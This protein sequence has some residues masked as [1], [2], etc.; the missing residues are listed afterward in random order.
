MLLLRWS[1]LRISSGSSPLTR[2]IFFDGLIR[3]QPLSM[4]WAKKTLNIS[5]VLFFVTGPNS[6]V[7]RNSII[8]SLVI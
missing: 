3:I 5:H 1:G 6:Q 8:T 4:H 7:F 2:F